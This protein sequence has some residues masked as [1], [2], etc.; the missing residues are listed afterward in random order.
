MVDFFEYSDNGNFWTGIPIFSIDHL[1]TYQQ[2]VI[3]ISIIQVYVTPKIK[4]CF[5]AYASLGYS[6]ADLLSTIRNWFHGNL[7]Y[8]YIIISNTEKYS[9]TKKIH[10]T[11]HTTKQSCWIS[12]L[13]YISHSSELQWDQF[14]LIWLKIQLVSSFDD[15]WQHR[16]E[17]VRSD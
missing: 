17:R 8:L 2:V 1:Y 14:P 3:L 13:N 5:I 12:P 15:Q 9:K 11:R 10:K 6:A 4:D 7:V 16:S